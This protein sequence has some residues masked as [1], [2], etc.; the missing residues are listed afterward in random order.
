[1]Y[2]TLKTHNAC[3]TSIADVKGSLQEQIR[4]TDK[5]YKAM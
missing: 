5:K 4:F 1:L 2:L 3:F